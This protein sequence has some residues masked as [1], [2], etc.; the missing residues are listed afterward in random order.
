MDYTL[1]DPR[2]IRLS[3]ALQQLL[4]EVTAAVD[5]LDRDTTGV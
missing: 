2:T 1:Q 3:S 5:K 4:G